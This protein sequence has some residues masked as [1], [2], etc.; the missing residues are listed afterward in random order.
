M[1][2]LNDL[3]RQ[4]ANTDPQLAKDLQRETDALADRRAFGLNFERHVPE[5]VELPGRPVRKND[6]VRILPERGQM[7]KKENERLYRVEKTYNDGGERWADVVAVNDP[8]EAWSVIID[9]LIV[10]AEFRDPIYPGLVSTGKVERGG[11]KPFHTVIN[12][13][14]YNALQALLFT[15][16]GK[17]D[18]IYID[19]PYNS[20]ARDWKYNNDYV[21]SDD[22]Y[23][24]SKWLAMM[25][26]RLEL[27]KELL[28]PDDSV[29]LITIDEKEYL[30][31]GLLIS[32]IFPESTTQ[33]V[34]T[35]IAPSG[36]PR[37]NQMSRVEEYIFV[38]YVGDAS[39][40]R[41]ASIDDPDP[42]L[43]T[44]SVSWENLVR[45]GT[46]A[47][48]LDR[49]NQFYPLFIDPASRRI[50]RVG[51]ALLPPNANREGVVPPRGLVPVWPIRSDGSEGRWRIS[52]D[53][54][55]RLLERGL[56]RLGRQNKN[57]GQWAVNYVLQSDVARLDSGEIRIDGYA[58][59]GSAILIR[60]TSL[61]SSG[62]VPKT[63]WSKDSHN[64]GNY[65]SAF[66]RQLIP[67]RAF[68]FPKSLYAV[69]DVLNLFVASKPSATIVDFFAGSG[70]TCHAVM[71]LNQRDDGSR[72]SIVVTNNEVSAEEQ[73][74]LRR[75]GLRPGDDEWE[76]RGICEYITK[77]RLSAAIIG[78]T[79][80]GNPITGEYK[81]NGI[82]PISEGLAENVEFFTLTYESAMRVSS[83]REFA[84]VAPFLWLRSGSRGRRISDIS[85]GWDVSE[86]YGVIANLDLSEPFIKA[87]E[88]QAGL[89]HAFIVTDEDRL[90]EAM[91]RQLP[92]HVEPV[93]LY[94]SYLRN[95]EIE[96][97]R[98][99]R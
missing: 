39:V 34:T 94:S 62:V 38:T 41:E 14:N 77:P 50:E 12:A 25:E 83:N 74:S 56:L 32:Q 42:A 99:A 58:E 70:T 60:T 15:H 73:N 7:P 93:R 30:R 2:R 55:R 37:G 19:P 69:E 92:E 75:K 24:H 57:S 85:D 89:T 68:P 47:R 59:N 17:V 81:F 18:A 95:F 52:A 51:D 28:N 8:E 45:R 3:L 71:R 98:A 36:Q 67:G 46:S 11:D 4:V 72:R 43:T 82:S 78:K 33:M 88:A 31:L 23:R 21:E 20:G 49:P 35:V 76:N 79:P 90:F 66:L 29:L 63:V 27:A 84:K 61:T 96:A 87:V 40:G 1:S 86:A 26:R 44:A 91:V 16:R 5:A 13:E 80:E 10:V 9:D 6:K 22:H 64:A 54:S 97:M 48:R 65:G 53:A